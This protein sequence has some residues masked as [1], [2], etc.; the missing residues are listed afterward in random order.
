MVDGEQLNDSSAIIDK[1][2]LKILSKKIPES[3]SE[4]EE[5]KWRRWVDNHLVHVLSPNI[6][7]NTTEAL[8]SFEYITSNGK[9]IPTFD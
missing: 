4:D 5:T 9:L 8:E 1:L 6:Y 7:R 3:T 2:G